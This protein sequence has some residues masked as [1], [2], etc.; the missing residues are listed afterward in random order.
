MPSGRCQTCESY[1]VLDSNGRGCTMPTCK[2]RERV[3]KAGIC[4]QCPKYT[5]VASDKKSCVKPGCDFAR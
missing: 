2:K 5:I 4:K 3:D 1:T